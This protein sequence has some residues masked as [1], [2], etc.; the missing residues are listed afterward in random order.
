MTEGKKINQYELNGFELRL[1]NTYNSI[2]EAERITGINKTGISA[3]LNGRRSSAG[4][5]FWK[6]DDGKKYPII[7]V[8][9]NFPV[10]IARIEIYNGFV[11][12]IY[13]S[14]HEASKQTYT[15]ISMISKCLKG[16]IANTGSFTWK[17]ITDL[18][19]E[20]KM[21]YIYRNSPYQLK[22]IE[23]KRCIFNMNE[24]EFE[25]FLKEIKEND[26]HNFL[27]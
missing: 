8:P 12:G 11:H 9:N 2:S 22:D 3:A 10:P 17:Y 1:V 19:Y 25:I 27:R 18:S 23:N 4:G 16:E 15:D 26:F 14:L 7:E 5:Y 6:F 13:P 21:S 20:Q 24:K